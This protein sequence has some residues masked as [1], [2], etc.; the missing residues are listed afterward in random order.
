MGQWIDLQAADGTPFRPGPPTRRALC[1]ARSSWG[2]K[3][4]A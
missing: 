4:L 3:F 1:V 2:K